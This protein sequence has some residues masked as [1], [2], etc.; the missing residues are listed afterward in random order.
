MTPCQPETGYPTGRFSRRVRVMEHDPHAE[1]LP[2]HVTPGGRRIPQYPVNHRGRADAPGIAAD[3]V[4]VLRSLAPAE[5]GGER[6]RRAG[7]ALPVQR[8]FGREQ[9]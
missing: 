9:K 8:N 1:A 5:E 2:F 7:S 4:Y 3:V 6:D